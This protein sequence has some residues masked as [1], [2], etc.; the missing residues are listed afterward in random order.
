MGGEWTILRSH[1]Y[2]ILDVFININPK[3][4]RKI[5]NEKKKI[6]ITVHVHVIRV[7][8]LYSISC[9]GLSKGI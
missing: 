3:G 8:I 5:K 2:V 6:K 1:M 4:N 9:N 7:F